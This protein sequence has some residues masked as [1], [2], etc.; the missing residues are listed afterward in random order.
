MNPS[1][2]F[3]LVFVVGMLAAISTRVTAESGV[4]ADIQTIAQHKE[5]AEARARRYFRYEF[6]AGSS[7]IAV[8]SLHIETTQPE[9]VDGWPGRYRTLGHA[10]LEF[11]D[12]KGGAFSRSTFSFEVLTE[13]KPGEEL[14]VVD[15]SPK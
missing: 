1:K 15:F 11:Y 2:L 4:T 12:S 13:Q 5:A 14:K 10:F 8:T 6:R 7:S 9:A 3:C